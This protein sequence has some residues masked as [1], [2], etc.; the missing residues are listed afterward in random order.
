[1]FPVDNQED[2]I[3]QQKEEEKKSDNMH[4]QFLL[5][6]IPHLGLGDREVESVIQK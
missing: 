6:T 3:R 1:L 4:F 5:L 2:N